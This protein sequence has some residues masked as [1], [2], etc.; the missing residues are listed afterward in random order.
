MLKLY[1]ERDVINRMECIRVSK[2][3]AGATM[4]TRGSPSAAG[5]DLY[6]SE[7]CVIPAFGKGLIKTDLAVAVPYG[8]YGRVA[9]RSGMAWKKHTD[10]GAGVIDSDYRGSV[11]IVMFNHGETELVIEKKDRVAQLIIERISM[12]EFKEVSF[13]ELETTERGDG[14]YGSTGN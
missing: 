2:L 6:A 5:W 4:P 3:S 9:P 13:S 12:A 14:G 1:K 11:G 7:S 8:Y 10:I